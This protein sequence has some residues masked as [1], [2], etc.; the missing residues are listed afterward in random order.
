MVLQQHSLLVQA[1]QAGLF[2]DLLTVEGLTVSVLE[3]LGPAETNSKFPINLLEVVLELILTEFVSPAPY[4]LA[5]N[6]EQ[7][8]AIQK[9]KVKNL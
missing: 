2:Q 9:I 3:E 4:K 1:V 7:L 8:R 5:E 6:P